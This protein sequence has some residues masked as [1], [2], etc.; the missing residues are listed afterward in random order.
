MSWKEVLFD[1]LDKHDLVYIQS[2][3]Y[4]KLAFLINAYSQRLNN[5]KICKFWSSVRGSFDFRSRANYSFNTEMDP[6]VMLEKIQDKKLADNLRI[7]VLHNFHRYMDDEEIVNFLLDLYEMDKKIV[8]ISPIVKIPESLKDFMKILIPPVAE[9]EDY[10]KV[11]KGL[12]MCNNIKCDPGEDAIVEALNGLSMQ[13]AEDLIS[14]SFIYTRKFDLE[15]IKKE[16]KVFEQGYLEV[17]L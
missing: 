10:V 1:V 11:I 9:K 14:M 4:S 16:K 7:Y 8:I 3:Q 5:E 13:Q 12:G 2:N 17:K 6:K 15:F